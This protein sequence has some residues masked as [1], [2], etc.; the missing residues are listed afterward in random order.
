MTEISIK[1]FHLMVG[2]VGV[3][4]QS[5]ASLVILAHAF[6]NVHA[7]Q[8]TPLPS[9]P[10]LLS[11]AASLLMVYGL[12]FYARAKGRTWLWGLFTFGFC[13]GWLLGAFILMLSRDKSRQ[14]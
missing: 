3:F 8:K 5:W 4:L 6:V 11:I 2:F 14:A 10:A 12:S 1:C 9:W 7:E 13:P